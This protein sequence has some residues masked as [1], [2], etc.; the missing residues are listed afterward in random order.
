MMSIYFRSIKYKTNY[1]IG[2]EIDKDSLAQINNMQ[3]GDTFTLSHPVTTYQAENIR[4]IFTRDG[5]YV[6][7]PNKAE[8]APIVYIPFVIV[9]RSAIWH[10]GQ[11]YSF[12]LCTFGYSV[13]VEAKNG[14]AEDVFKWVFLD[15]VPSWAEVVI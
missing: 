1:N 8:D 12:S 15:V 7:T 4:N 5:L 11:Q 10:I 6:T 9:E 13:T 14:W 2:F 3:V